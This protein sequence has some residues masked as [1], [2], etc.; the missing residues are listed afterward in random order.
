MTSELAR[1][2]KKIEQSPAVIKAAEQ[3]RE[4]REWE[5]FINYSHGRPE[6]LYC[7]P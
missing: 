5:D 1:R 2:V 3:Q 6:T 7:H 4:L